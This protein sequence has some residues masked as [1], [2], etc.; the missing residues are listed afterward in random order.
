[1]VREIAEALGFEPGGRAATGLALA[2]LIGFGQMAGLFLTGSSVGL[3]VHGLLPPD[4]RAEFGFVHWF[5]AALPLHAVMF[6]GGLAAV[7]LL[8][9]PSTASANPGDRLALQRAVLG[10]M[11]GDEKLCLAVLLGLIAGFLTESWHGINGAWLGV[12]ALVVLAAGRALDT[13]MMRTGINWPFLIFFGAIS[14]LATVFTTLRT[15]VWLGARLAVP[16]EAMAA[17]SLLFCLV[18]AL[19]GFALAFIVRWQ[20]AAPL[21]SLVALPAASAAGV[22]PFLVVLIALVSTQVWFLP[23]QSTVYLAL[24]HGSGECFSHRQARALA[25]AWGPLVLLSIVCA[26]PVWRLMGLAR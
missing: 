21:L 17:G 23:Y 13:T 6:V 2:A 16:I 25:W 18:L 9:R 4:I 26:M 22:H 3:L 12:G 5:V 8:Y 24:Y 11:R 10:P 15:D 14:S 1:M 19:I 7:V 20:A